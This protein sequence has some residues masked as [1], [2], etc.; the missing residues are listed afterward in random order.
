MSS[1]LLRA[2]DH[3]E[4]VRTARTHGSDDD[5]SLFSSALSFVHKNTV[6]RTGAV[7]HVHAVY[8][9]FAT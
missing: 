4:A 3:E 6:R 5:D 8:A 2:V 1:M 7:R 9:D